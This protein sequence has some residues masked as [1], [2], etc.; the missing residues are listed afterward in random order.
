MGQS[1][2]NIVSF[3][4]EPLI[5]VDENNQV[6]GYDS[7]V[8]CHQGEGRLHRA[9]SLFVFNRNNELLLQKRSSHKP[10][11][12]L[13]WSNSCCSH[14]RRGEDELES[15]ERRVQEELAITVQPEFLY[16]F[17][18][19]A[20]FGEPGTERELCSVYIARSDSL[21][22]VNESEIADWRY[23][24]PEAMD[25]KLVET[26]EHYTPWLKLEWPNLRNNFWDRVKAL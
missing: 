2:T 8:A 23:I 25:R 5:L 24:T 17:S 20:S 12:P 13:Y 19:H 16:R 11:W 7:K 4:E 10:L 22:E 1:R 3:D 6:L 9:F 21:V 26:P 14:P 18:Y 15:V